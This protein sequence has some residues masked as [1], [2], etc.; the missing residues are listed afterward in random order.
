[1]NCHMPKINEG[2]QDVV[3]TH[4]IFS[5]TEPQMIEANQPNACNLCHLDEPL[6][7]TLKYFKDWYG[8]D[9][10]YDKA[11]LAENYPAREG[12]VGLGWLQSEH[13][14][15]RLA[16]VE[17][18]AEAN[19]EWALPEMIRMLDDPFLLNRQFTQNN[20]QK[21]L[22]IRLEEFGYQFYMTKAERREPIARLRA[23]IL[24]KNAG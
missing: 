23:A 13:E 8:E 21:M 3:R 4:T 1:M 16:A 2:M 20:L 11:E 5:P 24:G 17:A 18:L 12:P 19:A 14:S 7:W 10:A 6:D 15:T 22:G 9:I